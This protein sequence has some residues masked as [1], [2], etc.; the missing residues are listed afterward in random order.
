MQN[1]FVARCH[2]HYR[3]AD[4]REL[5]LDD[6]RYDLVVF[7]DHSSGRDHLAT[8]LRGL[9]SKQTVKILTVS[10]LGVAL[11]WSWAARFRTSRKGQV[12]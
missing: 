4:S 7:D 6:H 9:V 3:V 2:A 10:A 12:S 1:I 8:G 5:A 11:L